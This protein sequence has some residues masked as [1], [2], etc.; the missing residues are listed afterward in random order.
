MDCVNHNGVNAAAYC[1]NC[2]K[3]LCAECVASGVLRHDFSGRILCD[4]CIA[5][6]RSYQPPFIAPPARGPNP[7]TAAA[8]GV[9]PGVGAMYNGQ[10]FKGFIHVAVFAVL[11]SIANHHNVFGIFIAAWIFYQSFEAFQ[12]AKA[13]RDGQPAPDPF[14]LNEVSNWINMGMGS[15]NP[16]PPGVGQVQPGPATGGNQPSVAGVAQ[17]PSQAPPYQQPPY[18]PPAPTHCWRRNEPVGAIVLIGLGLMFFLGQFDIFHGRLM[19]F[20]WPLLLI[21]LGV[22]LMVRRIEDSQGGSK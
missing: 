7:A 6:W 21:A 9:I 19:D 4:T 13:M 10:F 14:G 18:T 1:Q 15:R 22:W 8:L 17:A 2:G 3:P 12:T 11:V 16:I 5:A 20:A